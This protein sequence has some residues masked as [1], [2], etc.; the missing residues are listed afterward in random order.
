MTSF[1]IQGSFEEAISCDDSLPRLMTA[2]T[3]SN[4][5]VTKIVVENKS[6]VI[7]Q[8]KRPLWFLGSEEDSFQVI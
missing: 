1:L 3:L 6:L 5:D 2:V 8:H 7:D 4:R